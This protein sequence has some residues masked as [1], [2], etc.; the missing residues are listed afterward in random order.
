M[1][2]IKK[3]GFAKPHIKWAYETPIQ[4]RSFLDERFGQ[5]IALKQK[6]VS[7]KAEAPL[8]PDTR[9]KLHAARAAEFDLYHRLMDTGGHLV[10]TLD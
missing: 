9:R 3:L 4:F 2:L 8:G 1:F 6:N 5:E 10:T 7:P